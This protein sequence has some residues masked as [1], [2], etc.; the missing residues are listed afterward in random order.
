ML[1]VSSPG[2]TSK[3]GTKSARHPV[4]RRQ[5]KG[6]EGSLAAVRFVAS[7][8]A[9]VWV[10]G[11]SGGV[12]SEDPAQTHQEI[13]DGYVDEYTSG[14]VG[15][16]YDFGGDRVAGHCSGS[17]IAPNLVL[18]A[19]HCVALTEGTPGETVECG[20]THFS[21]E[22]RGNRFLVSPKTVRPVDVVDPN[23]Y[24]GDE[25][26]V[27]PGAND[28]CGFDVALIIL[29]GAGI[30]SEL[31][32]PLVPRIDAS[33]SANE[34]FSATGYGLTEPDGVLSGTRMRTDGNTVRCAGAG[35]GALASSQIRSSEW[36]SVDA[37]VCP[38][39]SGGPAL[40]EQGR[41]IGVAS[42]G[43]DG[44]GSIIY[45][46]VAS[47]ADFIIDTALD[48]AERGGYDAPSWTSG[49][50]EPPEEPTADS[51]DAIGQS[52]SAA[53]SGGLAC[54]SATGAP[55]GIC[56]PRCTEGAS[57]CPENYACSEALGVC[58]P[59]DDRQDHV[60]PSGCAVSPGS[61]RTS[62]LGWLLVA[63]V[64]GGAATRRRRT[65][66]LGGRNDHDV[67]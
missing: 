33:P 13:V 27:V 46:D 52:C 21:Y 17:L 32:T 48:A 39:D 2:L 53:C 37:R 20:V 14:V 31:A 28:I 25:V 47:W 12:E 35:C 58:V 61:S 67:A 41:V 66:F 6:R 18:T 10:V 34:I 19:R 26:R 1:G 62:S 9:T 55:P 15:L 24:R 42:R 29:Q 57:E 45:G 49:S 5:D 36:L 23:L 54:Y 50:S 30:P 60:P 4:T 63:A 59:P 22:G 43:A 44:C 56:V 11:C 64:V 8:A 3:P 16:A 40:D 65:S 38:G 51:G 7:I